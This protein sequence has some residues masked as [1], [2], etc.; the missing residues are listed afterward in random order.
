MSNTLKLACPHCQVTSHLPADIEAFFKEAMGCYTAA[1]YN[2]FASM[3]RRTAQLMF[4]DLGESNKLKL[5]DE[6]NRIREM[7]E[8]DADTYAVAKKVIFGNENEPKP[9]LPTLD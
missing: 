7:A 1:C 9:A 2:A 5:F 8:I 6:L 4:A 3:C